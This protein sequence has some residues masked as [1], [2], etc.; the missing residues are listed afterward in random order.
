M[1]NQLKWVMIGW[2]R[3]PIHFF[4]PY[5]ILKVCDC[6]LWALIGAEHYYK[7]V[8][9][10]IHWCIVTHYDSIWLLVFSTSCLQDPRPNLATAPSHYDTYIRV[11]VPNVNIKYKN[12][13]AEPSKLNIYLRA[14]RVAVNY[15]L[16][17]TAEAFIITV[18]HWMCLWTFPCSV[19]LRYLLLRSDREDFFFVPEVEDIMEM[20]IFRYWN[21]IF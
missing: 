19:H 7:D 9:T 8:N 3:Q 10:T 13:R 16:V 6:E 21:H 5:G 17:S 14:L 1:T 18:P 2:Y 4:D 12:P 11:T 20:R 15:L